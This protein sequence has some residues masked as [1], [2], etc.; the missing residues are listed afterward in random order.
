MAAPSNTGLEIVEP[1]RQDIDILN[2]A[3]VRVRERVG[4]QWT[5]QL[6]ISPSL[7][8]FEDTHRSQESQIC[9]DAHQHLSTGHDVDIE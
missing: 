1:V 5:D 9:A 8:V 3:H 6:P 4:I 2:D 7:Q